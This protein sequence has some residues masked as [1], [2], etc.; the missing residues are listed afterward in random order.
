MTERAIQQFLRLSMTE[1][2]TLAGQVIRVPFYWVAL[3][4][5]GFKRFQR[6]FLADTQGSAAN[7]DIEAAKRQGFLIN[8]AVRFAAGR[9]QCLLRSVMLARAL[10]RQGYDPRIRFG[11][12]RGQG[13]FLAHS[14]VE[15]DGIPV[16]DK[17]SIADGHHTLEPTG[18]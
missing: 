3:R 6:L 4:T 14:W 1:K 9:D 10:G 12:R 18:S 15:I 2:L 16:N 5:M 7:T 11:V 8:K 17:A 13:D